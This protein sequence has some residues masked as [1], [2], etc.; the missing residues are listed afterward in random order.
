MATKSPA[1]VGERIS[2]DGRHDLGAASPLSTTTSS[3]Q[4]RAGGSAIMPK[5]VELVI[6]P[7]S[8]RQ[9]EKL[10]PCI[11]CTAVAVA[12]GRSRVFAFAGAS[13]SM[14]RRGC[15]AFCSRHAANCSKSLVKSSWDFSNFFSCCS[16]VSLSALAVVDRS[17]QQKVD[18]RPPAWVGQT[19][20]ILPEGRDRSPCMSGTP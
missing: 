10:S 12:S 7:G 13:T 9:A 1:A 6:G 3:L 18:T 11:A 17:F 14:A 2:K 16:I 19:P 20:I 15:Q 5:L 8:T 4:G